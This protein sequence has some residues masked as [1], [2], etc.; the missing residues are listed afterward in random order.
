M[1]GRQSAAVAYAVNLVLKDGKTRKQAALMAGV[2]YTSVQRALWA[3]G[4][5]LK[6]GNPNWV[7]KSDSN[8]QSTKSQDAL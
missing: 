6:P 8:K 2:A 5:K 4:K 1:S 3:M 7:S